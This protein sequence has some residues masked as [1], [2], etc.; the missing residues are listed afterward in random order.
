MKTRLPRESGVGR[1][2]TLVRHE[3]YKNVQLVAAETG[4]TV[5]SAVDYLLRL[6]LK[7]Y[8]ETEEKRP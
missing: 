8:M 7:R 2:N 6:G 3:T 4:R 1:I 5:S